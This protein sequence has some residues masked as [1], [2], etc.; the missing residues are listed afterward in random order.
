M[1]YFV[2]S[3]LQQVA[4]TCID[5]VAIQLA[6]DASAFRKAQFLDLR[7]AAQCRPK[8]TGSVYFR[9]QAFYE[10]QELASKLMSRLIPNYG[11]TFIGSRGMA[12]AHRFHPSVDVAHTLF[13]IR[14]SWTCCP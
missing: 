7:E 13:H 4:A 9:Y 6:R 10:G 2:C 8:P 3:G 12:C 1:A 5:A 11:D 14:R